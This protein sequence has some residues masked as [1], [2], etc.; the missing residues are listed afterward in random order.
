[1]RTNRSGFG[2]DSVAASSRASSWSAAERSSNQAVVV[3]EGRV[4][5]ERGRDEC[6]VAR[7]LGHVWPGP[8]ASSAN[9]LGLNEE[10]CPEVHI[11]APPGL[12]LT[13]NPSG[14]LYASRPQHSGF[15][16]VEKHEGSRC[17]LLATAGPHICGIDRIEPAGARP[18]NLGVSVL[19][20]RPIVLRQGDP[21]TEAAGPRRPGGAA[22]VFRWCSKLRARDRGPGVKNSSLA[23]L[24]SVLSAAE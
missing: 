5:G 19:G 2:R 18:S 20:T 8:A 14:G 15:A 11:N 17:R 1:M 10:P 16:L 9:E 7:G 13:R 3:A 22:A 21:A 6:P 23:T 12:A 24:E 4:V